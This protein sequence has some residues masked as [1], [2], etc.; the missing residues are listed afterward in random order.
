[1]LVISSELVELIGLCHRAYVISEGE[2]TGQVI[3]DEMTEQRIM[4]YAIPR[5]VTALKGNQGESK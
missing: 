2:I 1:M 4:S 3:G 5:R